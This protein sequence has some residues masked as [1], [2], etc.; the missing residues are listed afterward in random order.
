MN[1]KQRIINALGVL[2]KDA[3]EL[4]GAII[5]DDCPHEAGLDDP[6]GS[7]CGFNGTD[8]AF[9]MGFCEECW[10]MALEGKE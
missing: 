2:K 1:K 8:S 4:Y 5:S 9:V 7:K 3:P 10:K 6:N